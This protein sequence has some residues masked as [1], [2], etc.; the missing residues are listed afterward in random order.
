MR[1]LSEIDCLALWESGL[2]RHGLDRALLM[3]QAVLPEASYDGLADWPLGR[4]NHALAELH[5]RCF[6]SALSG[7][8][9]CPRC[10]EAL[11]FVLDA[12]ALVALAPP[13]DHPVIVADR[14]YRV[15]STRDLAAVADAIDPSAA[16]LRLL[17]RCVLESREPG[18]W[19]ESEIVEIGERLAAADPL[20]ET[21]VTFRCVACDHQW[22]ETFDIATFLWAEIASRA[23]RLTADVHALARAYGW[24]E[25]EIL[26]LGESRRARY[27]ELVQA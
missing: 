22:A 11:E 10:A 20:A 7:W 19:S 4:R 17:Q 25:T 3:L 9:P 16:S 15:L 8:L 13:S 21:R 23:R 27:L 2:P 24:T 6:G 14:A 18:S 5:I 12:G 26:A 1:A